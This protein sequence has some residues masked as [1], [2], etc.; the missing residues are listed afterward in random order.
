MK[1]EE[2]EK[3]F[4]GRWRIKSESH[5]VAWVKGVKALCRDFF[6]AGAFIAQASV[7]NEIDPNTPT[8][9]IVTTEEANSYFVEQD[10][11]Y[12]WD[13]YDKKRGKDKCLDKWMKLKPEERTECIRVTPAYVASTPDKKYRKDPLTYLNGKCWNDEII[14]NNGTEQP[15]KQDAASKLTDILIG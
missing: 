11:K 12:W 1:K 15:T 14:P 6:E 4:E 8:V 2:I 10:F 7:C 9:S 3:A 5:Q 13:M